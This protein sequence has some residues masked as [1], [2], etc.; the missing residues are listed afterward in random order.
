M[1]ITTNTAVETMTQRSARATRELCAALGLGAV[2]PKEL[3]LLTIALA[4][5]ATREVQRSDEFATRLSNAFDGLRRNSGTTPTAGGRKKKD[6]FDK[7]VPTGPVDLSKL[8]S[9]G[10][11]DPFALYN[12][13]GE[14][15]MR[16]VLS[17]MTLDNLKL[18][19]A[20]VER[21]Y[22]DAKPARRNAKAP[23]IAY[24]MQWVIV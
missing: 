15:Q 1:S 3:T 6:I 23:L 22:P 12:G 5:T 21:R 19:A 20:I 10:T 13:Y 24:I 11:I 16:A 17:D 4:E 18:S 8:R 2:K 14:A 7:L 9:S